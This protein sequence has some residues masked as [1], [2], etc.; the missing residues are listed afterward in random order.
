MPRAL[1]LGAGGFL[2]HHL[3][4]Y[5]VERGWQ[6][7]GV[8][9]GVPS[10]HL[11]P[12]LD[13]LPKSVRLHVVDVRDADA[14]KE[15]IAGAD[16]VFPFAGR[17]GA[18]QSIRRPSD[19]LDVNV[20][21]HL[22]LLETARNVNPGV[23]LVFPGSRLQYGRVSRLPVTE[24]TPQNPTS[25]YGIHKLTA[26]W[27]Y[28]LYHQ[29][30]GL[31]ATCLRISLPYGA[32]QSRPDRAFGLV[33]TFVELAKRD[34]DIPLYGGGGQ[35]RDYLYV[36][37]L[38]ELILSCATRPEAIGRIYNAG[39]PEGKSI[40]SMAE[41]VISVVGA[42]SIVHVPWPEAEGSIETGDYVGDMSRAIEELNW[43]PQFNLER[44]LATMLQEEYRQRGGGG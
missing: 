41:T 24:D 9:G 31:K 12:R 11:M 2:G 37:D 15:L 33:G 8:V 6:V 5:L 34:Q 20:K 25:I 26:E 3:A 30:Y 1:V 43:R 10:G 17:S 39:Y 22:D 14:L 18:V 38:M 35:L 28:R 32:L 27:Y 29:V 13:R 16:A 23:R 4:G 42:G 40:R 7:E 44:G 21:S 19:D 36:E